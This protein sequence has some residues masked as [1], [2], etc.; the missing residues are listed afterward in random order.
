MVIEISKKAAKYYNKL[1]PEGLFPTARSDPDFTAIYFNFAFDQVLNRKTVLDRDTKFLVRLASLIGMNAV[2]L[3][4][5]HAYDAMKI[6]VDPVKIKEMTYQASVNLG[7][8]RAFPFIQAVNR[9]LTDL[10]IFDTV[11]GK[12][13]VDSKDYKAMGLKI[14]KQV[15]GDTF[16]YLSKMGYLDT[17]VFYDWMFSYEFG[18]FYSREGL[19]I[20]TRELISFVFTFSNGGMI[21]QTVI[22]AVN[23][24]RL[25]NDP[26]VL[27]EA[28]IQCIP[29]VGFDL[30]LNGLLSINLAIDRTKKGISEK[31][32]WDN[33]FKGAPEDE[34]EKR[35]DGSDGSDPHNE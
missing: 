28:I 1:R 31:T 5:D 13:T 30:A 11:Q 27:K 25:G 12:A 3:F 26:D 14:K 4:E 10:G 29:Y 34:K 6:G 32:A 19:D 24:F 22:H 21:E 20:K 15:Y 9:K 8:G 23:C 18:A 7:M 17:Q 2:N 35:E 16:D 33:T